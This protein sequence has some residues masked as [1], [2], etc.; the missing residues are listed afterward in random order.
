MAEQVYEDESKGLSEGR[1]RNK[2]RQLDRHILPALGTMPVDEI[3]MSDIQDMFTGIWEAIPA[4]APEVWS[5][6]QRILDQCIVEGHIERGENPLNGAVKRRLKRTKPRAKH[7]SSVPHHR[8]GWTMDRIRGVT[9][10]R[11]VVTKLCL[12]FVIMTA[13]RHVEARK[14][15]GTELRWKQ[16]NSAADWGDGVDDRDDDGWE[17]VDW[18]EFER[19][20]TKTIVWFIPKGHA[21]MRKLH[22]IPLPAECLDLL[23][24][25]RALH[26]R[27]GSG[28]VFP[29]ARK[30]HDIIGQGTLRQFCKRHKLGGTPHGC[31]SS[32]GSWREDAEVPFT[33]KEIALAHELPPVIRAYTRTDVLE[34]RS[35]LMEY[36]SQYRQGALPEGWKWAHADSELHEKLTDMTEKFE[37][38]SGKMANMLDLLAASDKRVQEAEARVKELLERLAE[39][40]AAEKAPAISQQSVMAL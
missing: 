30:G 1:N 19:G 7:F 26:E 32:F 31:R 40:E 25:A 2:R 17:V 13:C 12:L 38:L 22:R 3:E 15:T 24:E 33:V 4:T 36:W 18:D 9:D 23:R 11:S 39:K 35:R 34:V 37:A 8:V 27:W 6:T 28:L 20:S 14:M 10:P 5:F 21:K 29:S 16:I